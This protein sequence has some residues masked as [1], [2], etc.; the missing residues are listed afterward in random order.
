MHAVHHQKAV[1][2]VKH[3][4]AEMTCKQLEIPLLVFSQ[5]YINCCCTGDGNAF[6]F[7]LIFL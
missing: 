1:S 5:Y 3:L 7:L 2:P 6:S 4:L